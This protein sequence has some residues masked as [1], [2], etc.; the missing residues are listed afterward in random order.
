MG[1]KST[2]DSIGQFKAAYCSGFLIH[3]SS[4]ITA[5]ALLFEKVYLPNSIEFIKEFSKHYQILPGPLSKDSGFSMTI[6][7]YYSGKEANPFSDLT[8]Q[9]QQTV[10]LYF[11]CAVQFIFANGLLFPDVFET[12]LF[13]NGQPLEI[14]LV[15]K[16]KPGKKNLYKGTPKP[17]LLTE[18]DEDSLPSLLSKGYVPVVGHRLHEVPLQKAVDNTSAK[19]LA[20]LLGMT[21]ISVLFPETKAA[22]PEVILEARERL[23]DHL[24]PF[25]SSM[26]KLSIDLKARIEDCR[27]TKE[28][29][30]ETQDLVDTTVRPALIDLNSKM[31]KER[32]NFFYKILS[33]TYRG[34]RLMVGNPPLTQQQLLTNALILGSDVVMSSAGNMK[35]IEALKEDAGLTFLLELGSFFDKKKRA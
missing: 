11:E 24:P 8:E 10:L 14:T 5:M 6:T 25:W 35:V 7:D 13:E 3:D 33:S 15:K 20:A 34:L 31:Q 12:P 18:N 9:Q 26:L 30:E 19:Q 23:S 2:M 27:N 29:F 28:I 16:G 4:L 22:E 17:L 32:K 21:S 1:M